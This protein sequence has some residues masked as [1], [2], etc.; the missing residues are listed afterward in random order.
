MQRKFRFTKTSIESKAL[1]PGADETN[2]KGNP[3]KDRIYRDTE[4]PG[5]I[6]PMLG[7]SRARVGQIEKRALGRLR[8][9]LPHT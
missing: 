7:V 6:A 5:F 2:L 4:L 1:P 9:R 3:V 8:F